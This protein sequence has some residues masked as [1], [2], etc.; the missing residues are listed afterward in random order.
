MKLKQLFF[1]IIS[2][3]VLNSCKKE[4]PETAITSDFKLEL[5]SGNHAVSSAKLGY[6]ELA[7]MFYKKG[8][9]YIVYNSPDI[10]MNI[11]TEILENTT[12]ENDFIIRQNYKVRSSLNYFC[13]MPTK[14]GRLKV[15]FFNRINN[16]EKGNSVVVDFT[17]T[18]TSTNWKLINIPNL[19]II[20]EGQNGSVFAV[21]INQ[22]YYHTNNYFSTFDK[23]TLVPELNIG[24]VSK[25]GHFLLFKDNVVYEYNPSTKSTTMHTK[26]FNI[27]AIHISDNVVFYS[28]TSA[29]LISEKTL[30]AYNYMATHTIN[31]TPNV[32]K[33][34]TGEVI[35]LTSDPYAGLLKFDS[36]TS[37]KSISIAP[38]EGVFTEIIIDNNKLFAFGNNGIYKS[39]NLGDSWTKIGTLPINVNP[40]TEI[41]IKNNN[42]YIQ[43]NVDI[44][45]YYSTNLENPVFTYF[46]AT[47]FDSKCYPLN[48]G[49]LLVFQRFSNYQLLIPFL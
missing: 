35:V 40:D 3:S 34:T 8:E 20:K 45:I 33:T 5:I 1:I 28:T 10:E 27:A 42:L 26:P 13:R 7:F 17:V 38:S 16:V 6:V 30:D 32:L 12:G 22:E 21:D 44:G 23:V 18:D 25:D 24:A 36:D 19:Q 9:P 14:P 46:K 48:N 29:D 11:D 37:T 39:T 43:D 41:F 4:E 15:R 47:P 2:L 49:N 31:N